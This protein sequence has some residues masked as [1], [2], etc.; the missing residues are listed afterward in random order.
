LTTQGYELRER[1]VRRAA[2]LRREWREQADAAA[3]GDDI[4]M[5]RGRRSPRLSREGMPAEV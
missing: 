2:E 4:L 3:P 1:V 5:R